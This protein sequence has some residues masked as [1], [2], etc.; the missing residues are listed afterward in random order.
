MVVYKNMNK[1]DKSNIFIKKEKLS[2]TVNSQEKH[3]I[4]TTEFL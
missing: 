2:V 3:N 4:L 1:L